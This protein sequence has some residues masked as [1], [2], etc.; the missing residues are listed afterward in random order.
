MLAHWKRFKILLWDLVGSMK[1]ADSRLHVANLFSS[2]DPD[3]VPEA[4]F[5]GRHGSSPAPLNFRVPVIEGLTHLGVKRLTTEH[6]QESGRG[7]CGI[8]LW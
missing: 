5:L 7:H 1:L 4:L 2:H 8:F 6:G 3:R